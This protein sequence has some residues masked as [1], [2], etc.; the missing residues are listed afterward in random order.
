M[1]PNTVETTQPQQNQTK[2]ER[3]IF[4]AW[5]AGPDCFNS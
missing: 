5:K 2:T 1:L 3:R 4:M